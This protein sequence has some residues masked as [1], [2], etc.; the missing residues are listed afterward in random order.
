M[1][2]VSD[3]SNRT[4]TIGVDRRYSSHQQEVKEV[5]EYQVR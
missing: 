1:A 3:G 4:N 2:L 5:A